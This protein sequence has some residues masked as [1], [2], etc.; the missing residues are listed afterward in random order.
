MIYLHVVHF[1]FTALDVYFYTY[2]GITM[3]FYELQV[4]CTIDVTKVE[5]SCGRNEVLK[6]VHFH[7]TVID[8]YYL[9]L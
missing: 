8:V 6:I 1:H 7:S 2:E 9:H 3:F 5:D 4:I